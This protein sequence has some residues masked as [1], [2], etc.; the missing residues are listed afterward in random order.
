MTQ[1]R[2]PKIYPIGIRFPPAART[3][4]DRGVTTDGGPTPRRGGQYARGT[5][6]VRRGCED[7]GYRYVRKS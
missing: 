6:T 3:K 2:V 7:V 1:A 4:S 5:V